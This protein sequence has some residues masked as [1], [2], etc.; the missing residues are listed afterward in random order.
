AEGRP[1]GTLHFA[2]LLR[3]EMSHEGAS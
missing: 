1:C 2:D 3:Q